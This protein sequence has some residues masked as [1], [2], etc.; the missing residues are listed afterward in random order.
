MKKALLLALLFALLLSSCARSSDDPQNEIPRPVKLLAVFEDSEKDVG[1]EWYT[2][3]PEKGEGITINYDK[4]PTMIS[5]PPEAVLKFRFED[6]PASLR[7]NQRPY[8]R[9]NKKTLNIKVP[10]KKG[11][12]M[13]VFRGLWEKDGKRWME[14]EYRLDVRIQ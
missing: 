2:F 7:I 5:L 4:M 8:E 14:I 11:T 3:F 12:Y 6:A 1:V 13:Y 10:V 9:K